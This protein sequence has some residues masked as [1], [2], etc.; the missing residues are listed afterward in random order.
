M[1]GNITI[2]LLGTNNN[3]FKAYVKRT[4]AG[5]LIVFLILSAVAIAGWYFNLREVL[6][7]TLETSIA[8]TLFINISA[9]V[10]GSAIFGAMFVWNGR[11][12]LVAISLL[13]AKGTSVQIDKWWF[14]VAS[15]LAFVLLSIAI[16]RQ[17]FQPVFFR[18]IFAG[19]LGSILGILLAISNKAHQEEKYEKSSR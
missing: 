13:R 9:P 18:A 10:I 16:A 5:G 17:N 3:S 12:V 6:F 1:T 4:L 2:G 8:Y 14:V 19:L 11:E 15:M 7:F